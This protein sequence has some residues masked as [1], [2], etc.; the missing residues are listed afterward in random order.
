MMANKFHFPLTD[1]TFEYD[2]KIE[3]NKELKSFVENGAT[4]T[5]VIGGECYHAMLSLEKL[6]L[7]DLAK[8]AGMLALMPTGI[9]GAVV[10]GANV[11]RFVEKVGVKKKLT[12]GNIN[13]T[14]KEEGKSF[15]DGEGRKSDPK[16]VKIYR[17][18]GNM[19]TSGGQ[20]ADDIIEGILGTMSLVGLGGMTKLRSLN[21]F[22]L[23]M[24]EVN[25]AIDLIDSKKKSESIDLYVVQSDI[26]TKKYMREAKKA[27]KQSVDARYQEIKR[28]IKNQS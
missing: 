16:I 1:L 18:I 23:T 5:A 11:S 21:S 22:Y 6:G 19:M 10:V 14:D 25:Y 26:Y 7:G 28:S 20:V 4:G 2:Y 24:E 12:D 8:I 3:T 27:W 15:I 17:S 13:M 9:L